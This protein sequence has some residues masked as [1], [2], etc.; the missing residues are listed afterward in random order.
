MTQHIGTKRLG[1]AII[2]QKKK[3]LSVP[4]IK[5]GIIRRLVSSL[6]GGESPETAL[7]GDVN[8]VVGRGGRAEDR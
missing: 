2:A 8:E 6:A 5:A 1:N 4:S 3:K 7:P